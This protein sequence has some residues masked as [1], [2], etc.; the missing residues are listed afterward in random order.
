MPL[1]KKIAII[2]LASAAPVSVYMYMSDARR[3]LPIADFLFLL[4]LIPWAIAFG[5]SISIRR[6]RF[7]KA[8]ED[9]EAVS[10]DEKKPMDGFTTRVFVIAGSLP[11]ALSFIFA[12][13]P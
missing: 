4:G 9:S 10:D 12:Y 5:L 6:S 7:E 2:L 8:Q 1:W 13:W 11:V 3:V